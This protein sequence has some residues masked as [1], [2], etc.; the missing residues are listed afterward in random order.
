[1]AGASNPGEKKKRQLQVTTPE[2]EQ[3]ANEPVFSFLLLAMS[4]ILPSHVYRG[5]MGSTVPSAN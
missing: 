1:M 2:T 4:A 5:D 3:V